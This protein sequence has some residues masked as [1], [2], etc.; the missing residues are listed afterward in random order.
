MTR[1]NGWWL[2]AALGCAL[3]GCVA[4]LD[5][6]TTRGDAEVDADA[7]V[8]AALDEEL[9]RLEAA[10]ATRAAL[11]VLEPASGQVI[12]AGRGP[13]GDGEARRV[14]LIGS[15]FKPLTIAAALDAGLDPARRF[16]GE[17]GRWRAGGIELRDYRDHGSLDARDVIVSSSNIGAAKIVEA[18]GPARIGSVFDAVGATAP[19][20][21][22]W[23]RR[24]AG[25][26]VQMSPVALARAY[27]AFATGGVLNEASASRRL[28]G[29]ASAEQVR[30]MLIAAVAGG[31]GRRARIEGATVGG[32]TGT[33]SDGAAL[34]AGLVPADAPRYVVVVRAEIEGEYGGS[35]AAPSFARVARRLLR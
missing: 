35:V 30:Q 4:E 15:T 17:G 11:V 12:A 16:S 1:G 33:T 22:S 10:G 3:S 34:F 14:A 19:G 8:R 5:E 2:A 27:G 28:F 32:K 7:Q 25:I 9:D 31:T 24:G 18:V 26:G 29:E 6:P 21:E 13:R 23:L 20:E